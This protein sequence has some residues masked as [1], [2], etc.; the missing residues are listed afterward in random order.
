MQRLVP[1]EASVDAVKLASLAHN[2]AAEGTSDGER[3]RGQ[4]CD[5]AEGGLRFMKDAELAQDRRAV[6]VDSLAREAVIGAESVDSAERDLNAPSGGRKSA[7]WTQVGTAND[8]FKDDG[9]VGR[10]PA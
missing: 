2:L 7:P 9:I 6:V 3:V 1:A 10:M 4:R 5:L 8:D